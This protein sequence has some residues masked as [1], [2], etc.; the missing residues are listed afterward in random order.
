MISICYNSIK[1][2]DSP[3]RMSTCCAFMFNLCVQFY[4]A[5]STLRNSF[6]KH[7]NYSI[8]LHVFTNH[9][10]SIKV[11]MKSIFCSFCTLKSLLKLEI[12]FET[13]WVSDFTNLKLLN[14]FNINKKRLQMATKWCVFLY[15]RTSLHYDSKAYGPF[16]VLWANYDAAGLGR[17]IYANTS[18]FIYWENWS[19]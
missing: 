19:N 2:N 5:R 10:T 3:W 4:N 9:E 15:L 1:K 18:S 17:I 11:T 7:K 16:L 8:W 12:I 13:A 14:G 6:F